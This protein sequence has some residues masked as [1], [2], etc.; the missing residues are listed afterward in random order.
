MRIARIDHFVLTVQ[1]IEVTSDF[2]TRVLGLMVVNFDQDRVALVFG[3]QK[4]NL[5]QVGNEYE[6]HA[7]VPTPGSGDFCL[8]AETPLEEMI[9]IIKAQGVEIVKGP[10]R[11]TGAQGPIESV[12]IHDPDGNIVEIANYIDE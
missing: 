3:N 1:D 7:S 8:I 6:P 10:V 4:I 9:A 12:Y 5:H 11:K 2:Y